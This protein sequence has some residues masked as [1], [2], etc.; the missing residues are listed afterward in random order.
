MSMTRKQLAELFAVTERTIS[1]WQLEPDFPAPHRLGRSNLYDSPAV[2]RWW[3]DREIGR[4]IEGEDGRMLDLSQERARL[5]KVQADRQ[6][7]LLERER[8]ALVS[9][10]LVGEL[11]GREYATVRTRL[12]ALPSKLA[13][14]VLPMGAHQQVHQ[15]LSDEI[16]TILT[17]MSDPETITDNTEENDD[18]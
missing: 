9:V 7:L 6:T 5:A 11:V 10:D 4:L 3:R 8:G 1:T 13:P 15:A 16:H 14:I 18:E 2:L 17:E 12:L